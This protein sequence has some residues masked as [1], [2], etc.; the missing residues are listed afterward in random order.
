MLGEQR[1][2]KEH[3]LK[4]TT[5]YLTNDKGIKPYLKSKMTRYI[6]GYPIIPIGYVKTRHVRMPKN[7]ATKYT[8]EGRALIHKEQKAVASWKIQWIRE[9]PIVNERAT[10]NLND[11]RISLFIANKVNVL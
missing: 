1:R 11:N 5:N 3:S 10:V 2:L 8:P 4:K 6:K 7:G 9:H